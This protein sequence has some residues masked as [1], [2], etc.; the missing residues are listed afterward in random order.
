MKTATTALLITVRGY[1]DRTGMSA[2]ALGRAAA[3]DPGFV[4]GLRNGRN[5]RARMVAQ[6]LTFMR[7][8]PAP[9]TGKQKR[10]QRIAQGLA[11]ARAWRARMK[12]YFDA[13][14][15]SDG[16]RCEGAG[17]CP[18]PSWAISARAAVS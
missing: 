12:P 6:V 9:L 7:D 8:N 3:N 16:G 1:L 11:D 13:L 15:G 4:T 18:C 5:P 2:T 10:E 14:Y 17:E